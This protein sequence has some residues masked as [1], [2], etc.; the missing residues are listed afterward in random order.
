VFLALPTY[1]AKC[2]EGRAQHI[3][4]CVEKTRCLEL[5][6]FAEYCISVATAAREGFLSC[7]V[8]QE[9][10]KTKRSWMLSRSKVLCCVISKPILRSS[11]SRMH[12]GH[13]TIFS[14]ICRNLSTWL[15]AER[16]PSSLV[17][18]KNPHGRLDATN[19]A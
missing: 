13:T 17:A 8:P 1:T 2:L 11:R 10:R 19:F 9:T 4:P 6:L 16:P 7:I 14:I 3:L 18:V 5:A 12:Y 15:P